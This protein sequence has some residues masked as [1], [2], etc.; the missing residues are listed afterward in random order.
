VT[1]NVVGGSHEVNVPKGLPALTDAGWR[2][3]LGM[4]VSAAENDLGPD[5]R[6]HLVGL[7][8]LEP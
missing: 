5:W 7:T 2:G 4:L 3:F 8:E 6:S 1:A